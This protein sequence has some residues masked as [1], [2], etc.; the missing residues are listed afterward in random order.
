MGKQSIIST[1]RIAYQKQWVP[2]VQSVHKQCKHD[3]FKG[4]EW[5]RY[6][7]QIGRVCSKGKL[8]QL[9]LPI[10]QFLLS[11][12]I[13]LLVSVSKSHKRSVW[14]TCLSRCVR[15]FFTATFSTTTNRSAMPPLVVRQVLHEILLQQSN[16]KPH[17]DQMTEGRY[18]S[19]KKKRIKRETEGDAEEMKR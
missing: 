6:C 12:F 3:T 9:W 18:G 17:Q 13:I 5:D 14:C 4:P 2:P 7:N 11:A 16:L 1:I 19:S 15:Q 10:Y 8:V